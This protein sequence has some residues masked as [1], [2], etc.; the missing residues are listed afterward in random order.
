MNNELKIFMQERFPAGNKIRIDHTFDDEDEAAK[1]LEGKEYTIGS[2]DDDGLHCT[3]KNG[4]TIVIDPEKHAFYKLDQPPILAYGHDDEPAELTDVR[5][6][7][8]YIVNNGIYGDIS[9]YEKDSGD[10]VLN[11][12]GSFI[13]RMA[14]M[15]F[16]SEL[17]TILVPLQHK[18]PFGMPQDTDE[19]EN[20]KKIV[21][22]NSTKVYFEIANYCSDPTIMAL[23]LFSA[24]DDELYTTLSVNLPKHDEIRVNQTFIDTNNNPGAEDFLRSLS[25]ARQVTENGI[26]VTAQSGYCI[27]PLYEFDEELLRELDERGYE[28]YLNSCSQFEQD[29][30]AED[31]GMGG[32]E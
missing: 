30:E 17:L 8:E 28:E 12:M 16:R 6:I 14:D 26:P 27:Y 15:D 23:S 24:E 7:A 25:G 2:I 29:T 21:E 9:M 4:S 32:M 10:F 11:T 3:D 19:A 13:D 5:Q 20:N 18:Y 31:I 1:E 22:Y